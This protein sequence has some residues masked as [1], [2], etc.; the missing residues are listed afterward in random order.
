MCTMVKHRQPT[1]YKFASL[2]VQR[3]CAV[4][5][6]SEVATSSSVGVEMAQSN[7]LSTKIPASSLQSEARGG[8]ITITKESLLRLPG[9]SGHYLK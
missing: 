6:I 4:D 2:M 7:S 1:K 3:Y 5:A 8:S 9:Q